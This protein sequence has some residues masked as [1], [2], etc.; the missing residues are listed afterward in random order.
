MKIRKWKNANQIDAMA[1]ELSQKIYVE[2]TDENGKQSEEW[3]S[4]TETEKK[5]LYDIFHSALL[6]LNFY[7]SAHGDHQRGLDDGVVNMAEFCTI[8]R[9]PNA[10]SYI[11][12]Y[13]PLREVLRNWETEEE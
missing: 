7:H 2:F 11:T 10:N 4:P 9:L 12:T 1:H 13:C 3:R 6:T 5:I 8:T